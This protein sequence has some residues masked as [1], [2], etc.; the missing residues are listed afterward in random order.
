MLTWK[1]YLEQNQTRFQDELLDFLRIP[2]ISALPDHA[3]AVQ[4]AAEWVAT[5]MDAAGIESVEVMPTGGHPVV[6]GEWLH[7]PNKPTVLIYGHFDTQPVDPLDLWDHPPF[8]PHLDGDR[9]YARGATDD[10]GNM[11]VPILAVEAL[12][13]SEGNLPVN[14]KFFFEGQEEIG[15]PQLAGFIADHRDMLACDLVLSADGGQWSKTEPA[16]QMGLRGNCALQIDVRG[17]ARDLHSG[18]FGGAVQNP[19]H[20]LVQ[21]LDSMRTPQGKIL[22]E[23]FYDQVVPLSQEMREQLAAAPFDATTY[24]ADLDIDELFGEPGY[25]TRER[26]WIRP[27]LE[28]NGIWGGFQGEGTKTVLPSEAHAKITCRLVPDQDPA[29]V[30]RCIKAHIEKHKP[31]GAKVA[32]D[33]RET[34]CRAYSIPPDHFGIKAAQE[35]LTEL[36]GVEPYR[37][38]MG[39]TIPITSL[40]LRILG[41]HTVVYAFGLPDERTHAPNEFYRISSFRRGQSAYAMLLE[42]LG[43]K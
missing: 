4:T 22:V 26:T 10:K 13:A 29:E 16:L 18:T 20:A 35:V 7:A 15:S 21:L 25:T 33:A 36:Y 24:K 19:I 28:V 3:A 40:L 42:K 2:S 41:A 27:T 23:G 6:Y 8:E 12:L 1:T 30:I 37:V 5:C 38:R 39:G 34:A 31:L 32:V 17:P 14:C 43:E 9:I 11:L